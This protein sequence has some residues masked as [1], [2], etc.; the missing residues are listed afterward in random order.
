[1]KLEI[2]FS[3]VCFNEENCRETF[4][5]YNYQADSDEAT[6]TFPPWN[7]NLYDKM[8]TLAADKNLDRSKKGKFVVTTKVL[9][10]SPLKRLV[11]KL[12]VDNSINQ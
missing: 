5:V 9:E 4:T 3:V 8:D 1:M 6:S 2:T 7:D 10:I 12:F 11:L